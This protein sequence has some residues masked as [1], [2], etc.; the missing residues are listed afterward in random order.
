MKNFSAYLLPQPRD[1]L[2]IGVFFSMLLG[3]PRLFTNDGDLGRHITVGNY[4]L[5]ARTIPATDIFSHT[6]YG[7][8][9]VSHEWLSDVV[10]ALVHRFMG[11]SGD[12][13]IAALLGAFTILIIYEELVKRGNFRLIALFV[14]AWV[15]AVSSIHWL[16]RPHMFTFFFIALWTYWLERVYRNERMNIW[17]FPALMLIWANMHGAFFAGFITLAA[18]IA[19]WLLEFWQG[20]QTKELGKQLALIG[21]L[22]F[23]I[24]FINPSG[25][26]LWTTILDF[27]GNDYITSHQVDHLSPNFHEKDMWPFLLMLVFALF[28]LGQEYRIKFREALLLAGWGAMSL[29]TLRNL[30]LFAVVTAPI[31]GDLLQPLAVKILNWLNPASGSRENGNVLRGYV[32]V[33]AAVLF[34]GFVLWRGIPMDQKGTGNVYLPDKMPV[35]AVD[36]L[37]ENPQTGNMFNQFVWGGYILYGL[38]PAEKVFIDGQTDFY[39]EALL[40]EYFEVINVDVGWEAVL[41]KYAVSWMLIPR[42]DELAE[43]LYSVDDDV[44]NVIYEDDI[45]VIFRRDDDIAVP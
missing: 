7:E 11:L 26:R 3:G 1:I 9:L 17:L 6:R 25:R 43:Y 4:I 40:R 27:L 37:K 12:V 36:W 23:A 34:F 5:D 28:A 45:A 2:F 15:A 42:D 8:R 35:Q 33:V 41:D 38:W 22:S 21:F 14:A 10:F 19:S 13:F 20:H 29:F 30:P 44:W 39:G 31:Y 18:Y 16:A 32:W 24:T